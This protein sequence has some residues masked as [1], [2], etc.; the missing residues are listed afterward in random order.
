[1]DILT[2]KF[3][4]NPNEMVQSIYVGVAPGNRT[5]TRVVKASADCN[6]MEV[7]TSYGP[8]L[9]RGQSGRVG[10]LVLGGMVTS[11][12]EMQYIIQAKREKKFVRRRSGGE[13]AEMCRLVQIQRNEQIEARRKYLKANPSEASKPKRKVTLH[14]PVG[15][16]Y[17]PTSEPGLKVVA[18]V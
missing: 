1:M 4:P 14:L 18:R 5:V 3:K 8:G 11:L 13:I 17:V 9:A 16:R 6:H 10:V 15:F 2:N 12:D 7:T